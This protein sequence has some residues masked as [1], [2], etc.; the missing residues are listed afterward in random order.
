MAGAGMLN[1]FSAVHNLTGGIASGHLMGGG[2]VLM[3]IGGA[4]MAMG[5]ARHLSITDNSK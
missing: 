2:G 4:Y 5:F 3:A 1:N